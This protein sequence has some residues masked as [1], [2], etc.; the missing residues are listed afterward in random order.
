MSSRTS[1]TI[2]QG[3]DANLSRRESGLIERDP[4]A[5]DYK[6]ATISFTSASTIADSANGL[7]LYQVNDTIEVRGSA[8]NSRRWVVLTAGAGSITVLPA[9][10]QTEGAGPTITIQRDS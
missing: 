1:Q 7:G 3:P 10:I 2:S 9:I 5:G 6:A 8:L 4:S